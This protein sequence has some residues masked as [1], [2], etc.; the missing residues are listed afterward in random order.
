MICTF[1]G[2]RDT[3]KSIEPILY[4]VLTDLIENKKRICFI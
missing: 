1:F 3:P 2:H 4:N